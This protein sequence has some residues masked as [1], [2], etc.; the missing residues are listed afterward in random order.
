MVA[1]FIARPQRGA[2]ISIGSTDSLLSRE[3]LEGIF[4]NSDGLSEADLH[5]VQA[6]WDDV[7]RPYFESYP[8]HQ[9]SES[10]R[11]VSNLVFRMRSFRKK[12]A[13]CLNVEM[14]SSVDDLCD[15]LPAVIK[16][17]QGLALISEKLVQRRDASRAVEDL[18]NGFE[19]ISAN[20][21]IYV[22]WLIRTPGDK[23]A[24]INTFKSIADLNHL[25]EWFDLLQFRSK[26][27]RMVALQHKASTAVFMKSILWDLSVILEETELVPFVLDNQVTYLSANSAEGKAI[28]RISELSSDDD[29]DWIVVE[30]EDEIDIESMRERIASRGYKLSTENSSSGAK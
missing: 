13:S 5:Q 23:S 26:K 9:P 7:W 6:K 3:S 10:A 14:L 8:H 4:R 28:R 27:E 1:T 12:N 30:P 29:A 2:P 19:L 17:L 21:I 16:V 24:T 25:N 22:D 20:L 11:E 15:R 18:H